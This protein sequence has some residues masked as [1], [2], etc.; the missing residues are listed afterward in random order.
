M[1]NALKFALCSFPKENLKNLTVFPF[2]VY[3]FF[4]NGNILSPKSGMELKYMTHW[5]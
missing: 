1:N 4:N 5:K 2:F 3:E